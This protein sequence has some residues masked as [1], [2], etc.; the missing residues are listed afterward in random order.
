MSKKL[1]LLVDGSYYMYR[2]Y[3]VPALQ[4]LTNSQGELTGAIF[5]V[6]NMLR[7]LLNDY[8]PDYFAVVFDAKGKTFRNDLY[9]EYKANR[10]PMPEE[11]SYQIA[12]MHNL[13][14]ALGLPLLMIEGV[15]ADDVLA[16]LAKQA[17]TKNIETIISTGD[18]D[19]AQ[20]V[21]EHIQLINTMS[22]TVLDV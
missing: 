3:H 5:G 17:E 10:P 15:E 20:L 8:D 19:L 1:L 14:R 6:I 18:K 2:A 9:S 16:T 22:D 11:L 13:I 21:N 4:A 7:K 12:P